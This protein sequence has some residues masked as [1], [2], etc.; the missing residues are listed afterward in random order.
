MMKKN[1]IF[2]LLPVMVVSCGGGSSNSKSK[3]QQQQEQQAAID[4]SEVQGTYLAQLNTLN[5]QVNGS[6]PAS[7]TFSRDED[8]LAVY[9]RLFAGSPEAWHQQFVYTGSRCPT[10][11]DDLNADGFIDITEATKVVGNVLVPM[12]SD[13][14]SQSAGRN[15]FPLGDLSGSYFY[16]RVTSF[17][18]FFKDLR[19]EDSNQNDNMVKLAETEGLNLT[20]RV[21]MILGVAPTTVLPETVA[22]QGRYRNFQTF[23]VACGAFS[24]VTATPGLPEDGEIPGPVAQVEEGQDR[25]A[26]P[27]SGEV[28]GTPGTSTGTG[29][30]EAG[31]GSDYGTED[32]TTTPHP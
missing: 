1:F 30:N 31:S 22:T 2:A 18:K 26:P 9:T 19:T 10:L 28:E 12:D 4:G 15:F 20:G 21:A 11:S 8:K 6:V 17:K 32:E 27:G 16:E 29:S 25:P 7:V 24:Q 14:S 5:P 3:L 23:P 13:L